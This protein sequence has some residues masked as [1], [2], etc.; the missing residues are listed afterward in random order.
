MSVYLSAKLYMLT[1]VLA[2]G[3]AAACPTVCP[4]PSRVGATTSS[5]LPF[6]T[7]VVVRLTLVPAAFL[8]AA[9]RSL[10]AF[11]SSSSRCLSYPKRLTRS[12]S[13]R[14]FRCAASKSIAVVAFFAPSLDTFPPTAVGAVD[15][16]RRGP[17]AGRV[18]PAGA[19]H[20]EEEVVVRAAGVVVRFPEPMEGGAEGF[21]AEVGAFGAGFSLFQVEK[22]SS[23]SFVGVFA[24]KGVSSSPSI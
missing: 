19:P 20:R 10:N 7:G 15:E 6:V 5:F 16:D 9:S 11:A 17:A 24:F 18:L 3:A 14:A 12:S 2:T 8:S 21:E 1:H 23:P 13:S 4:N 22:K